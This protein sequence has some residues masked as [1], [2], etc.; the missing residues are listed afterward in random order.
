[1]A[2]PEEQAAAG[3]YLASDAARNINGAVRPVD[4]GWSAT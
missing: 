4:H 2:E 3:D 1:V